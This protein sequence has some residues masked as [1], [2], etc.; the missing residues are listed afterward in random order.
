MAPNR[1]P[2]KPTNK[3]SAGGAKKKSSSSAPSSSNRISKSKPSS[4]KSG[5]GAKRPPPKEVK[6]KARTAPEQQKKKKVREY[7][8]AELGLPRLNM[9]TPV[10]V[11]KPKGKKKG[12]VFVDDTVGYIY[13]VCW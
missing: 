13:P 2:S 11:Q 10:S 12:K 1:G 4:S 8:E 3:T 6:S 5:G 9:I 7:T